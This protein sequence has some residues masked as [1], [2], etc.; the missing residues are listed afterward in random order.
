MPM[1]KKYLSTLA[2]A[3]MLSMPLSASAWNLQDLLGKA[4]ES[5]GNVNTQDVINLV[6]GL[7]SN[8]DFDLSKLK[9]TWQVTGSAVSLKGEDTLSQIGGSAA[10]VAIEKKLD[11]YYTKYGLTGSEITFDDKGN[12]TLKLKK[13]SISGIVEKTEESSFKTSFK[14][15][16]ST[17]LAPMDTYFERGATGKTLEV[18]WDAKKALSLIQGVAAIVNTSST[19]TLSSLLDK[20][21]NVYV[22]FKLT[23]LK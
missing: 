2:V 14:T 6:D 18:M 11:P 23:R 10:T 22:G 5:L 17:T 21:D 8:S 7:F 1:L 12:F 19:N 16:G 9:G 15:F 20:Y 3:S 4:S 13:L